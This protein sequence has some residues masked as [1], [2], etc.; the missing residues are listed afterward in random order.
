VTAATAATSAL[1]AAALL[2]VSCR[3][4]ELSDRIIVRLD[5]GAS[6][7][8]DGFGQDSVGRLALDF[9]LTNEG[10]NT[11]SYTLSAQAQTDGDPDAVACD[12]ARRTDPILLEAAAGDGTGLDDATAPVPTLRTLDRAH[13]IQS[14]A[15]DVSGVVNLRIRDSGQYRVFRDSADGAVVLATLGFAVIAPD[16]AESGST[17]D[18]LDTVAVYTLTEGTYRLITT[19]PDALILVEEACAS[20]R[21]VPGTCPGATGDVVERAIPDVPPGGAVPG[22]LNADQ[23]GIGNQLV[24][25]LRCEPVSAPCAA[26]LE[27]YLATEQ[28]DCRLDA[29]CRAREACSLEGYC[30]DRASGGC[31]AA[32]SRNRSVVLMLFVLSGLL[33]RRRT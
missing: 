3:P 29:D 20:V 10:V 13:E 17:C 15:G 5:G 26:E 16:A 21:D 19:G 28:L 9:G 32:P 23:L 11:A 25:R 4:V 6:E 1:V 24:V 7:V 12:N 2:T 33:L 31:S 14:P 8:I 18:V 27:M 30:L 22:R